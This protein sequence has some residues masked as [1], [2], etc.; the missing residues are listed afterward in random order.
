MRRRA[1][2]IVLG[3]RLALR[4]IVANIVDNAIK[5]GRVARLRLQLENP[6]P[7]S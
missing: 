2:V 3:D 7:S 6:L 5:Y 1:S 4:R